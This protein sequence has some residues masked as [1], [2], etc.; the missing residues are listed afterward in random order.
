MVSTKKKFEV[1]ISSCLINS[2]PEITLL[3][4]DYDTNFTTLPYLKQLA[5]E[6]KT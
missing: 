2:Q 4:V 1:N 6:A 5:F 3:G